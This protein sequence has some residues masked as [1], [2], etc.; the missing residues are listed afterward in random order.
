MVA[1]HAQQNTIGPC[2]YVLRCLYFFSVQ[3]HN[4][5]AFERLYSSPRA[6]SQQACG[7]MP[8]V[9]VSHS[10]RQSLPPHI[11]RLQSYS[12][13]R[14][15]PTNS[16]W[17]SAE[18]KIAQCQQT[19]VS[20]VRFLTVLTECDQQ[21]CTHDVTGNNWSPKSLARTCLPNTSGILHILK[22]HCVPGN[23][24][25]IYYIIVWAVS[26]MGFQIKRVCITVCPRRASIY[27]L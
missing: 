3:Y 8:R 27:P 14:R 21:P 10:L 20:C 6:A 22:S 5:T 2:T 23:Q 24:Y 18:E 4:S 25:I 12:S 17:P 26:C 19:Y 9:D 13:A 1:S 7:C 16:L 15:G 11:Y